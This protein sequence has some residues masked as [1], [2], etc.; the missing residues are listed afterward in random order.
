ML[1][2]VGN[3]GGVYSIDPATAQASFVS[4]LSV[5]LDGT[6]FGV[7]FNPAAGRLRIV[8]DAG[9]NLRHN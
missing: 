2:G 9:Q 1:Y 4:Q 7:D 3:G 5:A 6:S 8:S